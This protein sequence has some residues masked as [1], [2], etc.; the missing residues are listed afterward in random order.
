MRYVLAW[1]AGSMELKMLGLLSTAVTCLVIPGVAQSEIYRWVDGSGKVHYSD[2]PSRAHSS[3]A[4]KLR[5]NTYAGVTYDTSSLDVGKKVIMYSASWC[6]VCKKARRYFEKK[7][8]DY[9]EYDVETSAK[10]KS[11]YRKLGARGVPV[12]L[13]GKQRMNGFSVDGFER[14]Y[15]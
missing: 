14:L 15:R 4:I 3:E 11:G 1:G 6:G 12:I 13:V 2:Q 9:T 7:G 8:I 10:G 5:I